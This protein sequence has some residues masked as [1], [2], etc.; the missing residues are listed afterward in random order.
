MNLDSAALSQHSL[1]QCARCLMRVC[2][3]PA[4]PFREVVESVREVS[5]REKTPF[6][7]VS[8]GF[9]VTRLGRCTR[10]RYPPT[11]DV[12]S[13]SELSV[14]LLPDDGLPTM[15]MSGSRA[16]L[17]KAGAGRGAG[18]RAS[19][20]GK[21]PGF[22]KTDAILRTAWES[23]VGRRLKGSGRPSALCGRFEGG[24]TIF[25]R[26]SRTRAAGACSGM[27]RG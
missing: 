1:F 14:V 17:A 12:A 3:R 11:L 5:C 25:W 6:T 4:R 2:S 27:W 15:P 24:A 7:S 19:S 8:P 13:V 21:D 16:I 9:S 10:D 22:L 23:V 18:E 20:K 26:G